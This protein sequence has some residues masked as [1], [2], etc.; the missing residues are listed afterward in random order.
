MKN[1]GQKTVRL[2]SIVEAFL[3]IITMVCLMVYVFNFSDGGYDAAH[4]PLV[5]AI[6]IACIV[7]GICGHSFSDMLEGIIER[8]TATLE[9]I[10]IL[11]TVG[12]LISSFMISGTIPAVIYYGLKL[13]TPQLFLPVGC[14][15]IAVVSLAC[16]SSWTATGT[17][18]IAF[19]TIG[20][21]LGISP[22]LTA[23]MVI[24]GAYV[25]DKFSPLSDT[26]NLASGVSG[27][28]LFDHVTAMVS[29]T[30][31]VFIISLI[32]YTI[33]GSRI[34]VVNYDPSIA[35]GIEDSLAANFNLN[36]LVLLP[37]A[38]IVAVC[39]LRVPGLPGVI[40]SVVTGV[41]FAVIFQGH[42]NVAEIFSVLHYGPSVETGNEFVD[43]ALAKGGM[44]HQMWTVN[45]ILLA[46]SFGGALEKCGSV[47]RIF[48]NVKH[49]IH[50]VGGL[51]FATMLTSIFCDAAMCDQFLGIGVPAPLY[52]NK[53]DEL[54]LAR[55]ML[56]RT[57]E[58]AGTLWACMFPWTACGAYQ[59]GI[60][61]MNPFVYFPFAFVNLLNPIY[62][63][64]TA[65]MGRN[66]FW[67]DGAYTNVF[68]K[69]TMRKAAKA[70]EEAHKYALAQLEKLRAEG[71]AP[72]V[73]A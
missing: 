45:L 29:T 21:G 57:L 37:I 38:V 54:G 33:L 46:V 70:P 68:G 47:E 2:P 26:T 72:K 34:D 73:N 35:Q 51:V 13:L 41:L 36:P 69:T 64:L 43:K 58:D 16:G 63:C 15:L 9:A 59:S 71:K 61:G 48:G 4:M 31:P 65:F 10:L 53:Y 62:A 40:I 7:G 25:G 55:N 56:S 28:G 8:L 19:M 30:G 60:L 49:K 18:G 44:D 52:D 32:L 23:G 17:I 67:A 50:T 6:C 22:A 12:L 5:I 11:L 24:S 39:I 20:V 42:H 66:I 14:M 3:P 1:D 27:T